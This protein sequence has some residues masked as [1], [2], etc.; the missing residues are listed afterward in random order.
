MSDV[1]PSTWGS[2]GCPC[3]TCRGKKCLI[4]HPGHD[5]GKRWRTMTTA[6]QALDEV[7]PFRQGWSFTTDP[8]SAAFCAGV[9][10]ERREGWSGWWH[11]ERHAWLA[12]GYYLLSI[13]D[14]GR[15]GWS[16]VQIYATPGVG[17]LTSRTVAVD[18]NEV[19]VRR[20]RAESDGARRSLDAS[21]T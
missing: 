15:A 4:G 11:P 19:D 12:A 13:R 3:C 21:Q 17:G 18:V 20:A 6:Y 7:S 10:Y 1:I 9:R 14:E 8:E 2:P 16:L 5:C